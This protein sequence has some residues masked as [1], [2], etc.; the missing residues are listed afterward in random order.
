MKE[1]IRA[2]SRK[3][4]YASL[5]LHG[6]ME[7]RTWSTKY[8]GKVLICA[9]QRSYSDLD[10]LKISDIEGTKAILDT[11][12][13]N[14]VNASI[15]GKAIAIGELIDC[16]PMTKEDEAKTFVKYCPGLW[17]HVYENVKEL[18]PFPWKGTQ[19]WKKLDF[20]LKQELQMAY[21][22]IFEP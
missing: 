17:C 1:E 12:T 5:M 8:R 4:P 16:R 18:I 7:T 13:S 2:L 10:I 22:E 11:L 6:K 14:R 21:P 19:G 9:S 20:W 3:Q 15:T